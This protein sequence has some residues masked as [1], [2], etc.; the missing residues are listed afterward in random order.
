MRL[1]KK[2]LII[3]ATYNSI[4][5]IIEN[6]KKNESDE[7]DVNKI[8]NQDKQLEQKLTIKSYAEALNVFVD[9]EKF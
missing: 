3:K 2:K 5:E 6:Y 8:A 9:S 1:I 4:D 7:D